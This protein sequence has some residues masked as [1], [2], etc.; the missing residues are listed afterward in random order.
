MTTAIQSDV[1]LIDRPEVIDALNRMVANDPLPM[2][3]ALEIAVPYPPVKRKTFVE[4]MITPV[5]PEPEV[6]HH[7]NLRQRVDGSERAFAA[8]QTISCVRFPESIQPLGVLN[9]GDEAGRGLLRTDNVVAMGRVHSS[10][11]Q[12]D[13]GY[14]ASR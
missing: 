3:K 5:S 12:R 9:S 4:V 13:A 14:Q 8:N 2:M 6:R 7:A 11:E 10:R 1:T